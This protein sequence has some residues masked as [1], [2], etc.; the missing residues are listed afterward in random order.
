[1][2][3]STV[4]HAW[5]P[6]PPTAHH[7]PHHHLHGYRTTDAF[8]WQ[9]PLS[10]HRRREAAPTRLTSPYW[11]SRLPARCSP[12]CPGARCCLPPPC[13]GPAPPRRS[14]SARPRWAKTLSLACLSGWWPLPSPNQHQGLL[15]STF[16]PVSSGIEMRFL[17][18]TSCSYPCTRDSAWLRGNPSKSLKWVNR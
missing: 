7:T 13:T 12:P 11:K 15:C 3:W 9:Q 17:I 8:L 14:P 5:S 1:M 16:P 18:L 2:V 4:P 6:P 10:P